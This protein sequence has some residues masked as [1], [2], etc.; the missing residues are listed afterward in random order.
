MIIPKNWMM[1]QPSQ[2]HFVHSN[3]FFECGQVFPARSRNLTVLEPTRSSIY[4]KHITYKN[5]HA[6]SSCFILLN[7]SRVMFPSPSPSFCNFSRDASKSGLGGHGGIYCNSI[8]ICIW[9][10]M[11]Q[12]FEC[13]KAQL[14]LFSFMS[15]KISEMPSNTMAI[16]PFH[17]RHL[18]TGV[19]Y[20]YD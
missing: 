20:L 10:K 19:F 3:S 5:T 18:P 12:L 6:S 17:I 7:S 2:K 4:N 8:D 15:S 11:S 1:C 16:S 9:N 13:Q 14:F